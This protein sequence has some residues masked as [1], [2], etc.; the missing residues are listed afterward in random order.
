[1]PGPIPFARTFTR[2]T[3]SGPVAEPFPLAGTVSRGALSRSIPFTRPIALAGCAFARRTF[4]RSAF[5][6]DTLSL[7]PRDKNLGGYAIHFGDFYSPADFQVVDLPGQAGRPLPGAA[8]GLERF[9]VRLRLQRDLCRRRKGEVG[10]LLAGIAA[11]ND[12]DLLP[13]DQGEIAGESC[14]STVGIAFADS[15]AFAGPNTITRAFT[16]TRALSVAGSF[17]LARAFAVTGPVAVAWQA[18]AGRLRR[19]NGPV[20][21][22]HRRH[23]QCR[24]RDRRE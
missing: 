14:R 23:Q 8:F 4:A 1:L 21:S 5:T 11:T 13:G 3:F 15:L 6:A 18:I 12:R 7:Q 16:I 19:L 20:L 10:G 24:A 2:R 22:H 17:A 9:H